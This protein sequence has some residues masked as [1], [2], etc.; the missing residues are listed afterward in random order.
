MRWNEWG[1]SRQS[2]AVAWLIPFLFTL[3]RFCIPLYKVMSMDTGKLV[4]EMMER[5]NLKQTGQVFVAIIDYFATLIY[6]IESRRNNYY[7]YS[8]SPLD[9]GYPDGNLVFS[10]VKWI[11]KMA[12]LMQGSFEDVLDFSKVATGEMLRVRQ[13]PA[14]FFLMS[15][16]E[17]ITTNKTENRIKTQLFALIYYAFKSVSATA[18]LVLGLLPGIGK[19]SLVAKAI[20]PHL[21]IPGWLAFIVPW[22]QAPLLL[23]VG[24]IIVQL[25]GSYFLM[26]SVVA[27]GPGG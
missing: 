22:L 7:S 1:Q 18:P 25:F 12:D 17:R 6:R 19:G 9:D 8:Y 23:T 21:S 14:R 13:L 2:L 24:V 15:A 10:F 20:V 26:V 3:L 11:L 4:D 16:S 5:L 27:G